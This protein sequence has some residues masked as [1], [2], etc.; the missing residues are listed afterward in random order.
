M[1]CFLQVSH[2]VNNCLSMLLS[3]IGGVPGY[4]MGRKKDVTA[5]CLCEI[6]QLTSDRPIVEVKIT[7]IKSWRVFECMKLLG[8]LSWYRFGIGITNVDVINDGINER[9]LGEFYASITV[10]S[11]GDPT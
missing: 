6:I 2:N 4:L 7:L 3:W 1:T 9:A 5:R 10:L 8:G 11:D